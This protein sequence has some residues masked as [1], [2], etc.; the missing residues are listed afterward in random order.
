MVVLTIPARLPDHTQS[1]T[2]LF[3][4]RPGTGAMTGEEVIEWLVAHQAELQAQGVKE[5]QVLFGLAQ[6]G[7]EQAGWFL[8]LARPEVHD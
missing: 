1:P 2:P 5:S 8:W 4:D 7:R 3:E 6:R